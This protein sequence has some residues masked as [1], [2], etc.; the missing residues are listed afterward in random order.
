MAA[1][2]R[3]LGL[4]VA[5]LGHVEHHLH[6]VDP[7]N[8]LGDRV[9][10]LQTGVD[11]EE[12]DG[13]VQADEELAGSGTD[14]SGLLEDGSGGLVETG[15]L[16]VTEERRRGLLDELLVTTLQGAV[17]GRDDLHGA[18]LVGDALGL[19]VTRLVEVALHE[20]L[21]ASES[22]DGLAHR[23]LVEMDDLVH[24][25]SDLEAATAASEGG[26]DSDRQAV[27]LGEL[28]DLL[29][30]VDRVGGAG[31]ERG[32]DLLGDVTGLNLVAESPNG[33]RRR[34]DPDEP[35]ID[36]SLGE[37]GVLGEEPVPGVDR[38][39]LGPT[40]N[41]EDLVHVKVGLSR[42]HAV[43]GEGL[44]GKLDEQTLGVRIRIDSHARNTGVLG[45]T[46]DAHRDLATVCD[47]YP[48]DGPVHGSSDRLSGRVP[49]TASLKGQ[50]SSMVTVH[51]F[52]FR[53]CRI[54]VAWCTRKI[55]WQLPG[56]VAAPARITGIAIVNAPRGRRDGSLG[57]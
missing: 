21:A 23:R 45:G 38:V 16:L 53:K 19:D 8:L 51:V 12:A 37:V 41:V 34:A 24:R 2:F 52:W 26:L 13:P 3:I 6:Q 25:A 1:Q 27:F 7:G 47:E 14:I 44:V 20:T 28:D 57:R 30:A 48:F 9:L 49:L 22:S 11:L 29:R 46:D 18:V 32:A 54:D 36:D 5:A 10:H 31:N 35:G 42:G 17:T 15:Q 50:R 4:E 43:E 40:G 39:D 55:R 56:V 33:L